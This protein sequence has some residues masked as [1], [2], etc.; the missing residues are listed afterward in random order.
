MLDAREIPNASTVECDVCIVGA[1]AAGITLA[2]ELNGAPFKVCILEGGG[3]EF[4]P[5]TQS[6]YDGHNVGR[7]YY[8]LNVCRLRY[9]GGT[10]N[11]WAGWC[12]PLDPMDFE[13]REWVPYSGWPFRYEQLA[14]FYARASQICGVA[15]QDDSAEAARSHPALLSLDPSRITTRFA[16][17]SP[18]VRFGEDY[19]KAV[20][21]AANL[22]VYLHAN[23]V[24]IAVANP[25]HKV[26]HVRV[27]TLARNAFCVKANFY[28]LATGGIENAR[29]LLASNQV[30]SR[31]LGNEHDLVG[32]FFMDHPEPEVGLIIPL[33]RDAS[34]WSTYV[35]DLPDRQP[36][37]SVGVLSLSAELQRREQILNS[38]IGFSVSS[39]RE[40]EGWSALRQLWRKLLGN[41]RR[42]RIGADIQRVLGDLWG[43]ADTAYRRLP[44]K[45][46]VMYR[47]ASYGQ[48]APN[49]DSRVMLADD[50]DVLGL[51]RVKLDWRLSD[52]DRISI[53]R[54]VEIL[55]QE[56]GRAGLGRVNL[57]FAAWPEQFYYG[58]HHIGTTRMS[59]HA[60]SG[61][62]D[63][64]CR[65]HGIGNLY[66][67]GSSLFPT[68]GAAP[69]T[70]TIVALAVRLASHLKRLHAG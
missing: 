12:R 25:P 54:T 17:L 48:Q 29:L 46:A 44:G 13:R 49:P 61:V 1:G 65:V 28:V 41:E 20:A 18:P 57:Q 55:A 37:Q 10:T 16:R 47:L 53:R 8:G 9:F 30:I 38:D 33:E 58:S 21:G 63:T 31:G 64:T 24:E 6:L 40:A 51:P 22:S 43:I 15:M 36:L 66:V 68:S 56:I 5:D 11:H 23:V 7:H 50:R 19:R 69:P 35:W 27:A 4:D 2:L 60:R 67:A 3:L 14:P 26:D 34:Y 70:L 42:E 39:A 62:V 59:E 32:R 52:I 45:G